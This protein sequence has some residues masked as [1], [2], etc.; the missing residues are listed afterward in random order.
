MNEIPSFEKPKGRKK[1]PL[2]TNLTKSQTCTFKESKW[3]GISKYLA[4]SWIQNINSIHSERETEQF[5]SVASPIVEI[6]EIWNETW[7]ISSVLNLIPIYIW[8][9]RESRFQNEMVWKS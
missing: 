3:G 7:W 1:N 4:V 2:A 5:W 8:C 9:H 6:F